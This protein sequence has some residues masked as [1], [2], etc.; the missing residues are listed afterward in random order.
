M[1][2]NLIFLF[3]IF[4][5]LQV[6][7]KKMMLPLSII[8]GSADLIVI[9]EIDVVRNN[10]Y[11]FKIS[12]TI[13][14]QTY[15]TIIVKMFEEWTCDNRFEKAEKGQKLFL[16]LK[17]GQNNWDLINGS[18]GE[19]FISKTTIYLGGEDSI[20]IVNNKITRNDM[21]LTTFTNTIRDFCKCFTFIGDGDYRSKTPQYFLQIGSDRQISIL[22]K[23]SQFS[24]KLFE[25]IKGYRVKKLLNPL[26]F[27]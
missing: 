17:K 4:S 25:E 19:L 3:F 10:T 23:R 1:K 24:T 6:S 9:G 22:E 16:F 12:E 14:G 2:K 15:K 13:K 21:S 8:A 11:R 20:K 27:Y 5:S 18:S 7:A 26:N